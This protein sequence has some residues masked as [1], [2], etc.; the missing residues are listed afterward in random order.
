MERNVRYAHKFPRPNHHMGWP[1]TR[2]GRCLGMVGTGLQAPGTKLSGAGKD[3]DSSLCTSVQCA[4]S[5]KE[6]QE[7]GL[8]HERTQW[9]DN[10]KR[11]LVQR[12]GA[13]C[14]SDRAGWLGRS[15]PTTVVTPDPPAGKDGAGT[16]LLSS[17]LRS[18]PSVQGGGPA[19]CLGQGQSD[20]PH[21]LTLS[22]LVLFIRL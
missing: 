10:D 21:S 22:P 2:D 16:N 6:R 11:T 18:R 13:A 1:G 14:H 3:T 5:R 19:G 17:W 12:G 7:T 20:D 15:G 4:E 9:P 8:F